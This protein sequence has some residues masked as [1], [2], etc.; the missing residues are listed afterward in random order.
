[1]DKQ[2]ITT[3]NFY[4][5]VFALYPEF[6]NTEI[7]TYLRSLHDKIQC[8]YIAETPFVKEQHIAQTDTVQIHVML[9]GWGASVA[10]AGRWENIFTVVQDGMKYYD[11]A[12]N[13]QMHY[14]PGELEPLVPL[15][16]AFMRHISKSV[17]TRCGPNKN[18]YNRCV[19]CGLIICPAHKPV[20]CGDMGN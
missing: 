5:K 20:C 12:H 10:S 13:Y 6:L 17:C 1:M 18:I 14:N 16:S 7:E 15:F 3:D 2:P 11:C 8:Y 9:R 4:E 19:V